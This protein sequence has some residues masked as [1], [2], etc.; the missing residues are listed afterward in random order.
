MEPPPP[1]SRGTGTVFLVVAATLALK[2]I[3]LA[4]L[5]DHPL[6]Q[7]TGQLDTAVYVNLGRRVAAGDFRLGSEPYFLA[8]LYAYFLGLV[9]AFSGGSLL[10][11]R[12]VQVVLGTMAVGLVYATTCRWF[13]GRSRLSAALLLAG[14]G[15]VSFYEVTLLQASLDPFLTALALF[16]LARALPE[17]GPRRFG[18]AG[19]GLGLLALNR[20]NAL[21]F[22]PVLVVLLLLSRG[23]GWV[24]T[25]AFVAGIGLALAPTTVRNWAVSGQPVLISSHGGLNFYIGNR[26][27]ADGTYRRIPGITPDIAGQAGDAQRVAEAARGRSLTAGEVSAYFLGLAAEWMRAHP[28][29]ALALLLRKMAYLLSDAEIS[30]NHSYTYYARDEPTLL[31]FLVVGPWL[32]VPLGVFGLGAR[33]LE[34]KGDGFALWASFLPVYGLSVAVFFV[35]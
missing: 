16:L 9:F 26:A 15:I 33:L 11:A 4:Q 19:L 21:V 8:P 29:D 24:R 1:A 10:A 13:E 3:V 12:A 27:G 6:L 2:L 34:R 25:A 28:G 23:R 32:L 7:P 20:P 18:A 30:L 5:H 22:A 17:G 35:T 31:R 14:A